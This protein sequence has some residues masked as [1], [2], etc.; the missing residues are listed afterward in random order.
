[1]IRGALG[2]ARRLTRSSTTQAP[3]LVVD[4]GSTLHSFGA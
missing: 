3:Q 4:G 2:G 1:M